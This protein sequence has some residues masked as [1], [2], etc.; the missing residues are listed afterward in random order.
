MGLYIFDK[1]KTLLRHVRSHLVLFRSPLK[2][3]EQILKEGVFE[4]LSELRAAGHQIA[5]AT[6]QLAVAHGI[7]T[8]EEAQ[9]LVENCIAKV[10]GVSAWRLSPYDPRAK[11]TI[12]GKPNPFARDDETRKPHP[13]ML[14]QIMNELGRSPKETVMVG[15][16][17]IDKKSAEAAGV[18]FID[19]KDFFKF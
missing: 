13:G 4:K 19:E 2:P 5:I 11:K 6:N 10:G 8:L 3:E 18:T 7:I 12:H 15:D 17:K 14:L 9:E 16:N 1:D